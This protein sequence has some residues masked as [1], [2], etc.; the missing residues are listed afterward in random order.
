MSLSAVE[1]LG[2]LLGSSMNEQQV[3]KDNI[4]PNDDAQILL[5]SIDTASIA[6]AGTLVVN[7]LT[8]ATDSFIL[9]HPLYC[10]LNSSVLKLDGGY[11]ETGT[12]ELF[13]KVY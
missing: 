7:K 11:D 8:Y 12:T 2:G 6:L 13:R 5:T 9:D 4:S 3:I 1:K 10:D